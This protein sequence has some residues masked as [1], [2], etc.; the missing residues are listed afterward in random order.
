LQ[1]SKYIYKYKPDQ[2]NIRETYEQWCR[3]LRRAVKA[4]LEQGENEGY[5]DKSHGSIDTRL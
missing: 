5:F 2:E 3:Q 1:N 4:G